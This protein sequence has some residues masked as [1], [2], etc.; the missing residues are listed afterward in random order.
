MTF[1]VSS[2]NSFNTARDRFLAAAPEQQRTVAAEVLWN[3]L[4]KDGKTQEAR[5]KSYYGV[6]AGA[7]KTDDLENLL[8]E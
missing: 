4:V 7:S 3:L 2:G 6:M 1:L 8:A 5:Y